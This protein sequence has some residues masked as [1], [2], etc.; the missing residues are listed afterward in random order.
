MF[1]PSFLK[2]YQAFLKTH[3]NPER[4]NKEK[5]YLYSDLK[6]YGLVFGKREQFLKQYKNKLSELTKAEILTLVEIL[7][8]QPSFEER[9]LAIDLL[10]KIAKNLDL[11]DLPLVEKLMRQSR[12]WALL[13]NL[14][15]PIMPYFLEKY[16]KT[17]QVL[18]KWIQDKD[19]WVR[20]SALL[21]QLLFFRKNIGGNRDLFFQMAKSQF[22]ESWIDKVYQDRLQNKR[23]KFFIRKA[24]G[25]VLREMSQKQP[26]IVFQFLKENKNQMSGLSFREGSRKLPNHLTKG[27]TLFAIGSGSLVHRGK[28]PNK[29]C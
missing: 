1:E 28:K 20:R 7:W 24:I 10:V 14:V 13:D 22:D 27:S 6:H 4:A 11:N 3:S 5:A 21:S 23:A 19:F 2:D 25:W 8:L 12:G 9:I 26:E 17:Y 18:K 29:A 15:I 16:P